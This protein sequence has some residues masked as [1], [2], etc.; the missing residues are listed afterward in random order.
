MTFICG[1]ADECT[2]L[3]LF[4]QGMCIVGILISGLDCN[5][6]GCVSVHI[7][8]FVGLIKAC[9]NQCVVP[10]ARLQIVLA[11]GTKLQAII[12]KMAL[13]I[14]ERHAVVQGIPLVQVGDKYFWFN[15]P[16]L[17]LFLIHFTLFQVFFYNYYPESQTSWYFKNIVILSQ[18]LL[19]MVFSQ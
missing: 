5:Q 3:F 12:T 16:K 17:L 1:P 11:V 8:V 18:H 10:F 19:K 14:Q 6:V 4:F 15:R 7:E 9:F 2:G 13:E